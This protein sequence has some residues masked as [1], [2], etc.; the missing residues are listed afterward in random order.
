MNCPFCQQKLTDF[1]EDYSVEWDCLN[2]RIYSCYPCNAEFTQKVV[3]D[4]VFTDETHRDWRWVDN[5][6]EELT[7]YRLTVE[8]YEIECFVWSHGPFIVKRWEP[9]RERIWEVCK[10]KTIPP[11][12]HPSNLADRIKTWVTFS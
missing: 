6:K 5:G 2:S 10:F 12:I 8:D 1:K 11:H 3:Y 4:Q 7:F 9:D